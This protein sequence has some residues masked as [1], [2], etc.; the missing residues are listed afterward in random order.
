[1]CNPN[2]S[3]GKPCVTTERKNLTCGDARKYYD[4]ESESAIENAS[5]W[6]YIFLVPNG[7]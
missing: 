2:K 1:M 3:A 6:A 5:K 7:T 4:A